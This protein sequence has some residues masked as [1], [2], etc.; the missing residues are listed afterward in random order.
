MYSPTFHMASSFFDFFLVPASGWFNGDVMGYG[1]IKIIH[2]SAF[3]VLISVCSFLASSPTLLQADD[4]ESSKPLIFVMSGQSNMDGRASLSAHNEWA[5][6]PAGVTFYNQ[7]AKKESFGLQ[8]GPEVGFARTLAQAMPNREIILVKRAKGGTAISFWS[9]DKISE[10]V[11][12]G[13]MSPWFNLLINE[14]RQ[15]VGEKQVEIAGVLWMQGEGDCKMKREAEEYGS[16]LAKLAAAFRKEL[17]ALEIPFIFG[18]V[19][20]PT[21]G[22]QPYLFA[23]TVRKAQGDYEK[24]DASSKLV[25]T[26]DIS[27]LKDKLHYDAD[28]Q[29][30]LGKRFAEAWLGMRK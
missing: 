5:Q 13:N 30:E 11:A 1:I 14:V 27:K 23:E 6:I 20:P 7:G 21:D 16:C 9:P 24:T 26:D 19:N 17:G 22:G 2:H 4:A 29:I 10:G 28:G 8:F 15:V 3:M 25:M 18:L 12:R